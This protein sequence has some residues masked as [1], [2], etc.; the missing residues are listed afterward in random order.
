MPRLNPSAGVAA[1]MVVQRNQQATYCKRGT[2][3]GTDLLLCTRHRRLDGAS[4]IVETPTKLEHLALPSTFTF[5]NGEVK[6]SG[7]ATGVFAPNPDLTFRLGQGFGE[8]RFFR[9]LLSDVRIYRGAPTVAE[10]QAVMNE[11]NENAGKAKP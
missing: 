2:S 6:S 9:G 8:G 4:G 10:V 3:Q 11:G 7:A 1:P 5:V